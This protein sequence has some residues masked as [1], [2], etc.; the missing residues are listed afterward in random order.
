MKSNLKAI[1]SICLL[2]SSLFAGSFSFAETILPQAQPKQDL[3]VFV[4]KLSSR[5]QGVFW[6]LINLG[7]GVT[8][9]TTGIFQTGT[10]IHDLLDIRWYAHEDDITV[11]IQNGVVD[12][13]REKFYPDNFLRRY[14]MAIMYVKYQLVKGHMKLPQII[15]PNIGRF[16]DVAQNISYAPYIAYGQQQSWFDSLITKDDDGH[17]QFKPNAFVQLKE[18]L[19]L[20]NIPV[21]SGTDLKIKRGEFAHLLVKWTT[22]WLYDDESGD[23]LIVDTDAIPDSDSPVLDGNQ[24]ISALR[25][26]FA[27]A[28]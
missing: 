14:E 20:M 13:N 11:L 6:E 18:I 23:D 3:S 7:R 5:L 15:F 8:A 9:P 10:D 1:V 21:N 24:V 16:S 27:L 26:M 25:T 17:K 2:S 4:Q 12:S 19:R 28:K 22:E